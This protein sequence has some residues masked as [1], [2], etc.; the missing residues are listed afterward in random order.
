MYQQKIK[1]VCDE[2][3]IIEWINDEDSSLIIDHDHDHY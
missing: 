1:V 2:Q 3:Q